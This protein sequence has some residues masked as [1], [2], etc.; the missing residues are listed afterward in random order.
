M[1]QSILSA[2]DDDGISAMDELNMMNGLDEE[3]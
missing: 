1:D 2:F 3:F